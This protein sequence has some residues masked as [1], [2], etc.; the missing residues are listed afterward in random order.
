MKQKN[1]GKSMLIVD[2][3]RSCAECAFHVP[4]KCF[5]CGKE[6]LDE[7]KVQDF[8]PLLEYAPKAN[9][10]ENEVQ[11][12]LDEW[13]TIG[14]GV[15][16]VHRLTANS[17]RSKMLKRRLKEYGLDSV[18]E[19]IGKVR[20][21]DFLL[22]RNDRGWTITFDWFVRPNNFPKVLDGNYDNRASR[23]T[24]RQSKLASLLADIRE[25]EG[26]D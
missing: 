19:A 20:A 24:D 6:V 2:T 11:A 5:P 16:P 13:N 3:P 8:C 1:G 23:K 10:S 12:V 4:P 18:I 14:N 7:G 15:K 9:G 25:E 26:I 21:S 22:G 17:D